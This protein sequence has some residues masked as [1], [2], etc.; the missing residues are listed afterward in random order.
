MKVFQFLDY[1]KSDHHT[2]IDLSRLEK[3]YRPHIFRL[4]LTHG[5]EKQALA[6]LMSELEE[7][8][9]PSIEV[10]VTENISRPSTVSRHQ[11]ST[12][13]IDTIN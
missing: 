7:N 10:V 8:F 4:K 12:A 2:S 6:L 13:R 11:D 1:K 9:F 5:Q 3:A